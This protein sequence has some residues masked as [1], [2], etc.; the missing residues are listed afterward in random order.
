MDRFNKFRIEIY[1]HKT[2]HFKPGGVDGDD[3]LH[4][5]EVV[6]LGVGSGAR[7]RFDRQEQSLVGRNFPENGRSIRIQGWL[8]VLIGLMGLET[9]PTC[10]E[11]D[12]NQLE[13]D[14]ILFEILAS[15]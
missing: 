13:E 7:C 3:G 1:I 11:K 14:F 10:G 8:T 9:A 4:V 12:V 6:D 5:L 15:R 2:G